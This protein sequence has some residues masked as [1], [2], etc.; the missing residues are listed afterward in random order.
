MSSLGYANRFVFLFSLL[1][2][3]SLGI[4][5]DLLTVLATGRPALAELGA[6]SG[7]I[8]VLREVVLFLLLLDGFLTLLYHRDRIRVSWSVASMIIAVPTLVAAII[9]LTSANGDRPITVAL[10]GLRFMFYLL[11]IGLALYVVLTY[12][13]RPLVRILAVL[14]VFM[15]IQ[16]VVGVAEVILMPP[17]FGRT[18]FGARAQGTFGMPNSFGLA[19]ACLILL[20]H[21]GQQRGRLR[22]MVLALVMTVLSGSRTAMLI[23]IAAFALEIFQNMNA[24]QRFLGLLGSPFL[25]ILLLFAAS[26]KALSGRAT[27][28]ADGELHEQRLQV[29]TEVLDA[30]QSPFDLLFGWGVGLGSNTVVNTFGTDSIPGIYISDSFYVF[31]LGS[32]GQ[33]G[34]LFYLVLMFLLAWRFRADWRVPGTIAIILMIGVPLIVWEDYPTNLLVGL[35]LA[36]AVGRQIR[37]E[38]QRAAAARYAGNLE[39]P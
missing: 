7:Q 13:E 27:M 23:G 17:V 31:L 9:M 29:W 21:V 11:P 10:I 32:F 37:T 18:I 2:L 39:F 12:G 22:W 16:S 30:I 14:K 15:L 36:W 34:L 20:F 6:N 35:S 4:Y 38:R 1:V 25:G 24:R 3:V 5:L 28:T 26:T 19:M 33:I 8:R